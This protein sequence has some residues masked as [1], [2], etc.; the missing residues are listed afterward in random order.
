MALPLVIVL[1]GACSLA[2]AT[3]LELTRIDTSHATHIARAT[4][5]LGDAERVL[6][7]AAG[8]LATDPGFPAAGCTDGLCANRQA[9][10]AATY[11]W[12]LGGAHR[13]ANGV[14]GGAF[15]IERLGSVSAGQSADCGG[16]DA[17]CEYHRVIAT[18][19]SNEVRRTLEACF[20]LRRTATGPPVVTRISWRQTLAP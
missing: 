19:V 10:A 15:W 2:V 6:R 7:E 9:P 8:Y 12:T 18:G 13:T 17:V 11:D 20:R 1:G 4:Q 5:A 14:G 16:V 3:L